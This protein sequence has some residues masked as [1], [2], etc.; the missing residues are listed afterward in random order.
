M[1]A[2]A[3]LLVAG[4][5][6]S[7]G[8]TSELDERVDGVQ[9]RAWLPARWDLADAPIAVYMHGHS[10]R[11][12]DLVQWP[13]ETSLRA[14]LVGAGYVVLASDYAPADHWGVAAVR[15]QTAA[16][17]SHYAQK[18]GLRDRRPY[19]VAQSMGGLGAL[20]IL[21]HGP[22]QPHA[23]ALIYPVCSLAAMYA[24]GR[25]VYAASIAEAA[26]LEDPSEYAVRTRGNDPL[27][28]P[29]FGDVPMLAWASYQDTLVPRRDHVDRLRA[30]RLVIRDC[31]G[32]H[33]DPSHFRPAE[34]VEFFE[35]VRRDRLW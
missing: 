1:R 14:A 31:V 16:L 12:T 22:L 3:L 30:R 33:G 10:G 25:G 9:T 29:D 20:G 6:L 32:D 27:D 15:T 4:A 18:L 34:L 28:R 19:L 7:T 11:S 35:R 26:G 21:R 8:P 13:R 23:V 17:V 24:G 5:L 2:L